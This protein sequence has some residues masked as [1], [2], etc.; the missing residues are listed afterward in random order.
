MWIERLEELVC[1]GL[2]AGVVGPD[3]LLFVEVI[4]DVP[5]EGHLDVDGVV[6]SC[7]E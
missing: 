6:A 1:L 7:G 2:R 5:V 4:P 3:G